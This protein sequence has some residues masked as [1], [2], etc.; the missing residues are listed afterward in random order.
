MLFGD[1]VLGCIAKENNSVLKCK[2]FK[3]GLCWEENGHGQW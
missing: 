1:K 3:T 2:E